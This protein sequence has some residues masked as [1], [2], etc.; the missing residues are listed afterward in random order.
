MDNLGLATLLIIWANRFTLPEDV[1]QT[2]N[3]NKDIP[4][5]LVD[6]Q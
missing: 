1:P 3:G 6:L 2:G 4:P 5:Y